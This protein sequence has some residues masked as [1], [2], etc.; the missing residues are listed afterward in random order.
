[1]RCYKYENWS[2]NYKSNQIFILKGLA[3]LS[4]NDHGQFP[5][6]KWTFCEVLIIRFDTNLSFT[7]WLLLYLTSSKTFHLVKC[8]LV[9]AW[10]DA[11][12]RA[13]LWVWGNPFNIYPKIWEANTKNNYPI[14]IESDH[15][16]CHKSLV[17]LLQIGLSWVSGKR[18]KLM[19]S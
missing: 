1:M 7:A 14:N 12:R 10:S 13:A 16:S 6:K 17:R 5:G 2:Q 19:L 4:Q 8:E 11:S 18:Y 3:R 15:I 9:K